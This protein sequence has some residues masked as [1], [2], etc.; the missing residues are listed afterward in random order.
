MLVYTIWHKN[1]YGLVTPT[2][3]LESWI[4]RLSSIASRKLHE[5]VALKPTIAVRVEQLK[6]IISFTHAGSQCH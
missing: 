2:L 5:A 1:F 3:Y 4:L 6:H